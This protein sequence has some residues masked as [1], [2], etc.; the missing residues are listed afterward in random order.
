MN[1]TLLSTALVLAMGVAACGGGE[2]ADEAPAD[3]PA[4]ET[5]AAGAG[6]MSMPS[7][8]Q[9]D[10]DART[11]TMTVTAGSTPDLNY[12]NYNGATNGNA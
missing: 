6:E 10:H 12:W 1:R 8:M 7:W 9:V 5:P 4:A 11:V 2:P 3:S